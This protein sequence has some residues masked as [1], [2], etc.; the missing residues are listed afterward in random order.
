[1]NSKSEGGEGRGCGAA[2]GR[3]AGRVGVGAGCGAARGR[4]ALGAAGMQAVGWANR[5]TRLEYYIY[6]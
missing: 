1:M 2:V 5:S 6:A 3:G 4:V